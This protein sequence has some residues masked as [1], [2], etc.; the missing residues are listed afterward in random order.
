MQQKQVKIGTIVTGHVIGC[1]RTSYLGKPINVIAF[2]GDDGEGYLLL[3]RDTQN[4]VEDVGQRGHIIFQTGG[5]Y[6]GYWHFKPERKK[7]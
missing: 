2:A 1:D 6:G 3:L 5:P 7:S 4:E